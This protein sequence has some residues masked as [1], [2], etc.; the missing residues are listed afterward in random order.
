MPERSVQKELIDLEHEWLQAISRDDMEKL[1]SIVGHEYTLTANGFPG[2]RTR[3]SRQEWMA[4][5]PAYEVHSYELGNIVVKDYD[6][7]AAVFVDLDLQATFRGGGQKRCLRRDGRVG[8]AGW[9]LAGGD[10]KLDLYLE[11][12]CYVE[13]VMRRALLPV[14]CHLFTQRRGRGSRKLACPT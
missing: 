6:A 9:A 12:L 2:G 3:I 1:E 11:V 8:Q 13:A 14:R 7:A 10:Q 5:V 4:T